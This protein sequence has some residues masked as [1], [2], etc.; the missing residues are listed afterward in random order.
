[1]SLP[2]D[3]I[4]GHTDMSWITVIW[5]MVA[6]SCFTLA[7]TYGLVWWWRRQEWG[8]A[9][10]ALTTAA[11]AVMAACESWMM[12]A[13]TPEE[14]GLALRWLH[15]PA[16]VF[17]LAL[18]GF[19]RVYLRAGRP[20]LAWTAC[21]VRTLSLVLNFTFSPNLNYRVITGLHRIPFLGELVTT[22]EGV[23]NPWMIV[24]QLSLLL[25]LV[26]VVDATITVWQ[27]GQRR[28]A[29]LIGCSMVFFVC[30]GTGQVILTLWGIVHTPLTLSWFYMGVIAGMACELSHDVLCAVQ[31]TNELRTSEEQYRIL[32]DRASDGIMLISP[33]GKIASVNESFARM[34]GRSTRDILTMSLLD[35]DTPASASG[36]PE[37]MR[38]LLAGESLTFETEHF[39]QHGH[40]FPLEVSASLITIGGKDFI[41]CFHRDISVRRQAEQELQQ[42]RAELTHLSRAVMLGELSGSL[43]H[44]LNQPLTAIL[45]NAQA[46][47]R[48]LARP[49]IDRD[50]LQE[51]LSDIVSSNLHAGE[52][53]RRLRLLLKKSETC[54]QPLDPN[55]VVLEVLKLMRSD[56]LNH[57]VTVE[58]HLTENLPAI[59]GDQVQLQQVLLNLVMNASDAMAGHAANQRRLQVSTEPGPDHGVRISVRDHGPGVPPQLLERVFEPFFTTKSNGLGLGLVVCNS[60]L[61]AHDG[62]LSAENHPD[63]GAVFHF[64]LP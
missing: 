42:R 41:Q 55:E 12:Y 36:I 25:V 64:T 24:G 62:T 60:I 16:W 43:A 10:F 46:A 53:I 11:T 63:G 5:S 48:F 17:I 21:A 50:E 54:H 7:V 47:Q 2:F 52:V 23:P 13:A 35:L 51:I 59:S 4:A 44:E 56:L 9:L 18:V 22:G 3:A 29:V 14:F 37:R 28:Q 33:D 34:H 6:G 15:V 32:F 39:H 31:L 57:H 61:L 58:I 40:A 8:Y 45:S 1:M 30:L 38:R 19:V 26:F 27:R 49:E 20:W